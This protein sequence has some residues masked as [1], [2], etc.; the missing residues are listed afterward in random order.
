MVAGSNGMIVFLID[1]ESKL[2]SHNI[3]KEVCELIYK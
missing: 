3:T 1:S 2:N